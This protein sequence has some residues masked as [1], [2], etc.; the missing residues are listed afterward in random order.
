MK[1][2]THL[3]LLLICSTATVQTLCAQSQEPWS[4]EQCI[5]HAIENNIQVKQ[6][7]TSVEASRLERE[8]AKLNYAPTLSA[9]VGYN[10]SFGR[11]LDQTTYQYINNQTVNNVNASLSIGTQ[12]FAG[13]QKLHQLKRSE[14]NLL[15]S[16]QDVE[17]IK[18]EITIAVAAAYLQVLYNKE[19]ILTS[20]AQL[21]TI[22]EQIARTRKLVDAGSLPLGS[23]LE[24]DAQLSAEKYNLVNYQNQLANSRL[25]LTQ[26]LELRDTPY[27]DIVTP[28]ISE[29]EADE[30][31]AAVDDIYEK[32][33]SLPQIEV[34]RLKNLSAQRDVSI[35]KARMYPTLSFGA[36]YGSSYSDARLRPIRD[37]DG[38][39]SYSGYPFMA[40]FG[41]NASGALNFN[42]SIP[43][44][45]GLSARRGIK[46]ARVNLRNSELSLD[47]AKD[48][49]YK[50]I[51]QAYTDATGALNRYR[52]AKSSVVSNKESFR[53][54]EQKFTAGA[55]TSVDYN[56]AKN[57]LIT[58]E[59]M[60]IQAKYEYVFKVKILEFYY[61]I[62]ITL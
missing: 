55:T 33:L 28:N 50:E 34:Q 39:T 59:S 60:M 10:A 41:D 21:S 6:S 13:M 47:L 62:A 37:P 49:L 48:R 3:S 8:Q 56:T 16:V 40:Q 20:Q 25:S 52:S 36:N 11:S 53:Y 42:L 14:F 5:R 30:P 44:F 61:G 58:A 24:L 57:N 7:K 26:L 43:I 29:I 1:I 9:S 45:N 32:A 17:R 19:Q 51:Q 18:N 35:A 12:L 31:K 23:L 2:K 54:A 22:D 4:I 15:A 46:V 38:Q 27:F